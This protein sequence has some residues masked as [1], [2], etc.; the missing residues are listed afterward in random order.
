LRVSLRPLPTTTSGELKKLH[1]LMRPERRLARQALN[2]HLILKRTEGPIQ[3]KR[4]KKDET[5]LQVEC[6]FNRILRA[7]LPGYRGNNRPEFPPTKEP[8]R[9]S[10]S[11]RQIAIRSHRPWRLRGNRDPVDINVYTCRRYHRRRFARLP[12]TVRK[13]FGGSTP[14]PGS[15]LSLRFVSNA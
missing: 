15:I 2:A 11:V 6:C 12:M 10:R 7:G 13:L 4:G 5:I 14:Y 1:M 8:T 9:L 3:R